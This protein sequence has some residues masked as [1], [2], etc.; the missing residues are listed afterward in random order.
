MLLQALTILTLSC[1]AFSKKLPETISCTLGDKV[2]LEAEVANEQMT[3][4]WQ[5]NGQSID[6]SKHYQIMTK[7][8]SEG[9]LEQWFSDFLTH[10]LL[11]KVNISLSPPQKA[12]ANQ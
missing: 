3:V 10:H 12:R 4:K 9:R 7:G 2:V 8:I 5:K 6:A 11:I 1:A